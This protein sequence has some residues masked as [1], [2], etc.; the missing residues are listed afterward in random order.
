MFN[1]TEE[2]TRFTASETFELN[3]TSTAVEEDYELFQ[4]F[5][6]T[7]VER[8]T[9]GFLNHVSTDNVAHDMLK[10]AE[11]MGQEKLQY[12]GFS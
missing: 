7:T 2:A 8:D 1:S 5:G 11:A 12:W 3:S 6:K 4:L 10:L 9:D